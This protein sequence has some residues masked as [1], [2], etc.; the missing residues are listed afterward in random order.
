MASS[1]KT[2]VAGLALASALAGFAVAYT[3]TPALETVPP[4][5]AP[6]VQQ[7]APAVSEDRAAPPAKIPAAAP[8]PS[9][10]PVKP[11]SAKQPDSRV[12]TRDS[13][14]V[15]TPG[16]TLDG[17]LDPLML[18]RVTSLQPRDDRDGSLI[19]R[20]DP[21]QPL[22]ETPQPLP[23][24]AKTAPPLTPQGIDK[25]IPLFGP[26]GPQTGLD[27]SHTSRIP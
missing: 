4:P 12:G 18:A 11:R 10:R 15:V 22:S 16:G 27:I 25:L 23:E 24:I 6:T 26:G 19:Q 8:L 13:G 14:R 3:L 20:V 5:K 7:A 21:S 1:Y 17:A 2:V 9:K